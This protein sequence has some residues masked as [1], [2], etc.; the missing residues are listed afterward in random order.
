M[1]DI[2]S[3]TLIIIPAFNEEACLSTLL[4]EIRAAAPASDIVVIND[5]SRDR[6]TAVARRA[7]VAVLDLPCNLGVGGAVQTGFRYALA[8]G[9]RY[10]LRCDGDGQHPPSEIPKLVAAMQAGQHDLIIGSRFVSENNNSYT[11]TAW[12]SAGIR[13]LAYML[14]HICQ[15]RVTDPTSGFQMLNRPLLYCFANSYPVDY[16][17]PESLALLRRQGYSFTEVACTFR[18]RQGGRSSIRSWGAFYYL[19]KVSLALLVDRARTVDPRFARH[20]T[21]MEDL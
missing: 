11:S 14:S 16:P 19:L 9:Y 1:K 17:E 10:V 13:G 3:Q 8:R 15:A 6:T 12:R 21:I 2:L 5:C 20:N 18:A 4:A 7:G